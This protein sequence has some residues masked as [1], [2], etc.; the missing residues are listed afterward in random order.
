VNDGGHV[1]L[2]L[3]TIG[4]GVGFLV[5]RLR[6]Y[7]FE[8]AARL[9]RRGVH[10]RRTIER[11]ARL[12][13]ASA[14]FSASQNLSAVFASLGD[15]FAADGCPRAEIRLAADFL[16]GRAVVGPL[17]TPAMAGC[18]D[19]VVVW[20]WCGPGRFGIDA[21]WWQVSLPLSGERGL[22]IGSLVLWQTLES[23]DAPL[24]HFH[25]IAGELRAQIQAKLL[26][27]WPASSD[28]GA[29]SSLNALLGGAVGL[30]SKKLRGRGRVQ[31]GSVPVVP[32]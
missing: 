10:Q 18:D 24:P 12:R 17:A 7:E 31:S 8:E 25:V 11:G 20:T 26:T 2:V 13:E 21:A 19:E 28:V 4:V 22:R 3:V 23:I 30:A 27:L 16:D 32:A 9:L 14:K 15:V 1:A 6:I 5:Q 29:V